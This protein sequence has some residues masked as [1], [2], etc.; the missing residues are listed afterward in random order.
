M[1][2]QRHKNRSKTSASQQQMRNAVWKKFAVISG[3]VVVIAVAA[4]FSI[5]SLAEKFQQP[6]TGCAHLVGTWSRPD[7]DYTI[8]IHGVDSDGKTQAAYFNPN[9][10]H[11]A[12]ATVYSHNNVIKLFIELRDIGYPGSKYDLV[13]KP[14]EDIL[15]GTY[16]QAQDQELYD[17]VFMRKN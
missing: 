7:G 12:L 2:Q 9:P 4:G 13:Y 8:C 1:E 16:F 17:V 5:Y 15:Q 3:V 11:V 10:I 6:Q 14:R